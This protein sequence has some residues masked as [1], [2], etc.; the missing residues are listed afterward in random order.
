MTSVVARKW[1]PTLG[2]IVFAVLLTVLT[3]PLVS[4]FFFRLYENELIRQ[5][6]AELIAQS[7]VLAAFLTQEVEATKD[8]DQDLGAP[9][10]PAHS[11]QGNFDHAL[12]PSLDLAGGDGLGSRPDAVVP[13]GRSSYA[14]SARTRPIRGPGDRR[15]ITSFPHPRRA[16]EL[17]SGPADTNR[18]IFGPPCCD[19]LP[20][21]CSS[22]SLTSRI[23]R[24][25]T[26]LMSS[27][28]PYPSG[29]MRFW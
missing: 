16:G 15:Q 18:R 7:A 3:L 20:K 6:E 19:D 23:I 10:P 28:S 21:T 1:R 8:P 26:A 14:S 13:S 17:F 29:T 24:R 9:I 11:G 5:T 2:M 4:L 22:F 25:A 27:T 12:Q